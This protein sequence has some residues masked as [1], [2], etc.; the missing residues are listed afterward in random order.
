MVYSD[1]TGRLLVTPGKHVYVHRGASEVLAEHFVNKRAC[2][3]NPVY[4]MLGGL[5]FVQVVNTS[6][7]GSKRSL[8]SQAANDKIPEWPT[9]KV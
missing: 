4:N 3:I 2:T 5:V 8:P 1:E 7:P 6:T 9:G